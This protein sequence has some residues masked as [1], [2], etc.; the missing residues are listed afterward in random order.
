[1]HK[2]VKLYFEFF[3]HPIWTT[4]YYV[5]KTQ[6]GESC[7]SR[8][9]HIVKGCP[10]TL[11]LLAAVNDSPSLLFSE[12]RNRWSSWRSFTSELSWRS[13]Y[14]NSQRLCVVFPSTSRMYSIVYHSTSRIRTLRR[15]SNTSIVIVIA[16]FVGRSIIV[17]VH[18]TIDT[19]ILFILAFLQY[20]PICMYEWGRS[21]HPI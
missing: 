21:V 13:L 10:F 14:V 20:S 1:M 7:F 5:V 3:R 12:W 16:L 9:Q 4:R 19:I 18:F 17:F 8:W 15:I 2:A 6:Q 11:M